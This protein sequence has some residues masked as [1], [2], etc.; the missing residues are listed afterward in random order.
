MNICTCFSLIF[1]GYNTG[2]IYVTGYVMQP[3]RLIHAS[4]AYVIF[5][6]CKFH[7]AYEEENINIIRIP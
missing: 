1:I 6:T 3:G 5:L 7:R 2:I 4:W